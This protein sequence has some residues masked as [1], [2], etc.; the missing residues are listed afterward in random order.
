MIVGSLRDLFTTD[1]A[2]L[3]VE[4]QRGAGDAVNLFRVIQRRL[5]GELD[6]SVDDKLD[7]H[8][9]KGLQTGAFSVRLGVFGRT[10]EPEPSDDAQVSD[11]S[12]ARPMTWVVDVEDIEEFFDN[13][14]VD[15]VG[16]ARG[17]VFVFELLDTV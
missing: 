5:R 4:S 7:I 13:G 16:S 14:E 1:G 8:E 11:V 3:V 2:L 17:S 10:H 9:A 6:L 12:F 15:G